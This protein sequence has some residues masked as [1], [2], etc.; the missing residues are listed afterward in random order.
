MILCINNIDLRSEH[1]S[2][3]LSRLSQLRFWYNVQQRMRG[4]LN[5]HELA[6]ETLRGSA[7]REL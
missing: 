7:L 5:Q 1:F 2:N 6:V 4:R 3:A